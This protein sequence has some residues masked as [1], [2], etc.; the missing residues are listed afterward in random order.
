MRMTRASKRST[1]LRELE[2]YLWARADFVPI[3]ELVQQFEIHRSTI[4]RML[5]DLESELGVVLERDSQKAVKLDRER[6]AFAVRLTLDEAAAVFIAA[7]LLARYSD[8]PNPHA[9]NA[10]VKLGKALDAGKVS[11]RI[12][13]HIGLTSARLNRPETPASQEYVRNL[14]A[15]IQAWAHGTRVRLTQREKPELERLFEPYFLEPSAVGYACYVIGFDHY[16]RDVRTFRVER[17]LR[18]TPTAE[19]YSIP[20]TF[21]PLD[22]LAGAWGINWG[23]H[24]TPTEVTLRFSPAVA[25]RVCE[26][27]WHASQQISAWPDG[28]IEMRLTV[29]STLEM[30]PWIRQW[31]P[32]VEVLAPESLRNEIANEMRQAGAQYL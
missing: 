24:N 14:Q 22:K 28:S 17:L 7:R 19:S 23:D 13:Q 32:D 20:S 27:T 1:R 3:R 6:S 30:K 5:I 25:A 9:V 4:F 16:R 18:V 26:S 2:Q 29:G 11:S 10:L 21:D 31:G 15:L 12:A 8:K